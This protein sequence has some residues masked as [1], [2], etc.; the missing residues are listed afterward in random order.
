MARRG[1]I[2]TTRI[3][4]PPGS[5]WD[6]ITDLSHADEWMGVQAISPPDGPLAKG[7][8]IGF[9]ARGGQHESTVTALE[10]GRLIALTSRPRAASRRPTPTG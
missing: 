1:F 8:R 3:D 4:A 6:Y 5:V 10:P 9:R 7:S 2:A